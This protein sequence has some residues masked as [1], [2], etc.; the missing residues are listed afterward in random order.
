VFLAPLSSVAI[1][2]PGLPAG[3]RDYGNAQIEEHGYP[4]F[5][6]G[7][8][9][10]EPA[11]WRVIGNTGNCCE[12]YLSA[13]PTGRL[14]DFGGSYLRFT[15]DHGLTWK[16]IRPIEPLVSGEGA[17]T[18]AP[19][20]DLIGMT[21]DP[22]SG[23]HILTFKYEVATE[24]WQY[25]ETKLHTPF[26]DRPWLSIVKGPFVVGN[27][28]VPYI[29]IL[30]SN[31]S[32][33]REVWYISFDGLNYVVPSARSLDGIVTPGDDG[34]LRLRRDPM[35]DWYQPQ[36]HSGVTPMSGGGA[37]ASD[38]SAFGAG[39]P[40]YALKGPNLRW[41]KIPES[42]LPRG[43][44]LVDSRD[45][46]HNVRA[47]V[48]KDFVE[49][50]VSRDGGKTWRVTKHSLPPRHKVEDFDFKANGKLRL[51]AIA[52]HARNRRSK[53]DQ[54]LIYRFA[55]T[56]PQPRLERV[57]MVG[58]GDIDIGRGVGANVRYD[59]PTVAILP[60]GSIATSF[61]DKAH[62]SPAIAILLGPRS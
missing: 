37:L 13:S 1:S 25:S 36:T 28:K 24:T 50:S 8:D 53:T 39:L 26:F 34:K 29:S 17:I 60:D 35:A 4:A 38:M 12:N 44:L 10:V 23:D 27:Q 32:I 61:A 2:A 56:R 30:M 51:T 20:G 19:N 58:D 3:Q 41:A 62:P 55:T 52:V 45:W 46:L 14:L 9:E 57:Y 7:G 33:W 22:Y 11:R 15:D 42:N 6:A 47:P 21:W 54:D 31:F 16:E 5:D 59:F 49:Y 18:V 40:A 43:R 48:G